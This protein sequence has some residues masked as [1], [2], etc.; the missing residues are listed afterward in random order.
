MNPVHIAGVGM[1]R[2]AK[3]PETTLKQLAAWAVTDALSDA[4]LEASTIGAAYVANAV[5]G[6]LTGQ[7]M[8]VGQTCL[9]PLGIDRIPVFNVEN[10][11]ASASSALHLAVQS[12]ASGSV[13][14]ALALG[15]EKMTHPDK[16][17]SLEVIGRAADMDVVR[18]QAAAL[19][20]DAAKR[21]YFMDLYASLSR[22]YMERTGA[23]VEDFAKVVVKAQHNGKLNPNAQYGSDITV[24]D[25]LAGREVVWPLSVMM[26]SPISD[27]AAAVLL[28]SAEMSRRLER[29]AVQVRGSAIASGIDPAANDGETA[30]SVAAAQAL[31]MAGL[32]ASDIDTVEVHDA[33][34]PAELMLYEQIGLAAPGD[35]PKLVRDGATSLG[36]RQP[37]NTSGGLLAK[38]HPIG[39][40]GLAQI[41]EVVTQLRGEAGSRQVDG[42]CTALTQ[43]G[44]G[45]VGGDN[46][47]IGV[48]V[49]VR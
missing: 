4:G 39:A 42:A 35:G 41:V 8:V 33:A 10:A 44:G 32:E 1:T 13:D 37:V 38:G 16:A 28:V 22:D 5:A 43:N 20:P 26:C 29:S 30:T 18:A 9:H 14:I 34:A 49:L 11:C 46:A 25:V 36:G 24:D 23:T 7:E 6:T 15:V 17:L 45:W 47:A 21:S 27:G 48:H 12:V 2:F 19:G 3:Q 40:T 31:S